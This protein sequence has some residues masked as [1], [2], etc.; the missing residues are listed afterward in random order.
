[1]G[2]ISHYY[3]FCHSKVL[4]LWILKPITELREGGSEEAI[5]GHPAILFAELVLLGY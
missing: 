1:M 4:H 2:F 3:L 5:L